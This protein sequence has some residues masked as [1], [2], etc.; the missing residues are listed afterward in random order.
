VELFPPEQDFPLLE[1][2]T[3]SKI[4]DI[5]EDNAENHI[6]VFDLQVGPIQFGTLYLS[7]DS[8]TF[9]WDGTLEFNHIDD[10]AHN[11]FY[12]QLDYLKS[13]LN[14]TQKYKRKF[15][16]EKY[17]TRVCFI[18]SDE[19][20]KFQFE[21]SDVPDDYKAL[22][23]DA[24]QISFARYD[25]QFESAPF[26]CSLTAENPHGAS[27]REREVAF[28]LPRSLPITKSLLWWIVKKHVSIRELKL[29][30]NYHASEPILMNAITNGIEAHPA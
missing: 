15:S 24:D 22:V 10:T 9:T 19:L 8:Y 26:W 14:F 25:F 1:P 2:I 13:T 29:R 30:L 11:F 21:Y 28:S 4:T 12:K 23:D 5:V 3:L 7:S 20:I 16:L 17:T 27:Y 6:E 18:V